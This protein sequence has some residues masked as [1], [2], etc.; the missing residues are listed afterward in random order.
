MDSGTFSIILGFAVI[1]G[2]G[3]YALIGIALERRRERK[4]HRTSE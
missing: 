2:L 4:N 3:G 1:L